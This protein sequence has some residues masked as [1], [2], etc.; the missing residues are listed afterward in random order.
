MESKCT[1]VSGNTTW[2]IEHILCHHPG[3]P[4]PGTKEEVIHGEP[5]KATLNGLTAGWLYRYMHK[6]DR[7]GGRGQSHI[8]WNHSIEDTFGPQLSVLYREVFLI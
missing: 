3:A 1:H 6:L 4:H 7:C 2:L 5:Y 8:Q